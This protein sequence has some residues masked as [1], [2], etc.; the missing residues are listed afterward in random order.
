MHRQTLNKVQDFCHLLDEYHGP[1]WIGAKI[2]NEE[3]FRF[4]G[5]GDAGALFE[6]CE[7]IS[8]TNV[9]YNYRLTGKM[10]LVL[11]YILAHSVWRY[12]NSDWMKARWSTDSVHFLK[13]KA[14]EPQEPTRIYACY[15]CFA[16]QSRLSKENET[17]FYDGVVVHR[18]PR[19]L[20]L[21]N[22]LLDIGRERPFARLQDSPIDS[23][24]QQ[25]NTD[26]AMLRNTLKTNKKWP[27]LAGIGDLAVPSSIRTEYKQITQACSD[28]RLFISSAG[29]AD[30]AE[31]RRNIL[32]RQIVTPLKELLEKL[33]WEDAI[34]D[35]E[36]MEENCNESLLNSPVSRAVAR[37][38]AKEDGRTEPGGSLS[39]VR[40]VDSIT[41]QTLSLTT[42]VARQFLECQFNSYGSI[43]G[44]LTSR[45][46]DLQLLVNQNGG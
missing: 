30:G 14:L 31:E 11:A 28:K 2:K 41:R 42:I 6:P 13:E 26:C 5:V 17:E 24:D 3:V 10:K 37:K 23:Y 18:Y 8:L 1:V 46:M 20:T 36:P 22:L 43:S 44:T 34:K 25:I 9:L 45:L 39:T 19:L 21:G 33:K 15:P 27:S 29:T 40:Y 12:Y 38:G 7:S 16:L 4:P 35:M 32:Y